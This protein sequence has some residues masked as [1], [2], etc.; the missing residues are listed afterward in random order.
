M[1][2]IDLL[3][4]IA[5]NEEVP[6]QIVFHEIEWVLKNKHKYCIDYYSTGMK[7]YLF[8]D[9]WALTNNLNDE[10]EI[11]EEETTIEQNFTGWKM[12]QSGKVVFS[13]DH[14]G[15]ALKLADVVDV[16]KDIKEM[17]E[18]KPKKIEK[19]QIDNGHIIDGKTG[20]ILKGAET[21]LANK[22][23]NIIDYLLEK[24]SDK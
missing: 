19:I 12:F 15:P 23:N 14:D 17:L 24:E 4:K 13:Y 8:C 9:E 1:K 10:I 5:N 21:I 2:V 3:N 7:R 20:Y 16:E 22:I 6:K 11:I 18:E